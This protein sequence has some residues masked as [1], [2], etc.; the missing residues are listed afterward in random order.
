MIYAVIVGAVLFPAGIALRLF[1][2][3]EGLQ[4]ILFFITAFVIGVVVTGI[5]RGFLLSFVLTFIYAMVNTWVF[6]PG[7]F[8]DPNVVA[9]FIM[10]SLINSVIG[11][12]LGA[13]G[14]FVGGRVFKK[15]TKT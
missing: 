10:F 11:G 3:Q 15:Q 9:A 2:N 6:L 13:G 14:G 7:V 8:N 12:A 1:A 5:K 4:L